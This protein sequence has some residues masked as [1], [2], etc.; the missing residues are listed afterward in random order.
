MDEELAG[1]LKFI[2]EGQFTEKKGAATLKLVGDVVPIDKIEVINKVKE[3]L[4]KKYPL[5]AMELA[6]KVKKILPLAHRCNVWSVIKEN[7]IKNNLDYSAY[8]F[9]NKKHKNKY[10]E[11]GEVPSGTPNIYN[12]KAVDFIVNILKTQ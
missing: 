11:A 12:H 8:N 10:K 9:R 1:K 2:K 7:D 6:D 5:S 4:I 3:N